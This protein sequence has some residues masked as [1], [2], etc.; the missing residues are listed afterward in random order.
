M[1]KHKLNSEN[2]IGW[3]STLYF[4][5]NGLV[6][7]LFLFQPQLQCFNQYQFDDR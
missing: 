5:V 4:Y 6:F 2:F 3:I 1:N 7:L